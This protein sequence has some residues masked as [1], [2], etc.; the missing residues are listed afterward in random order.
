LDYFTV[1]PEDGCTTSGA[2]GQIQEVQNKN[3]HNSSWNLWQFSI[4]QR[5][6]TLT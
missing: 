4:L 3:N 1:N 2:K 5:P 6:I